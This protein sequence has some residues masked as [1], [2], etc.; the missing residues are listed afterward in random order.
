MI[1]VFLTLLSDRKIR[2]RGSQQEQAAGGVLS[3]KEK[4]GE[5]AAEKALG[6]V[7]FGFPQGVRQSRCKLYQY[8]AKGS[9]SRFAAL[10]LK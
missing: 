6:V 10:F 9:E 7:Y 4:K 2:S 8:I 3:R 1:P 5:L